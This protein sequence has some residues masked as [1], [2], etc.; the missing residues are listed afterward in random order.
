MV[1][2]G[3]DRVTPGAREK[4]ASLLEEMGAVD[5]V[6]TGAYGCTEMKYAWGDCGDDDIWYHTCPTWRSSRSSTR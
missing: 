5:P 6:V 4:I 2:L 3:A 1:V